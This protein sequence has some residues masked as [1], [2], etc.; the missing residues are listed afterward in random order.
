MDIFDK[1]NEEINVAGG[2]LYIFVPSQL[3]KEDIDHH[4]D[5][6]FYHLLHKA[7]EM[8]DTEKITLELSAKDIKYLRRATRIYHDVLSDLHLHKQ[9]KEVFECL[10]KESE[11]SIKGD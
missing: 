1:V 6:S 3:P 5:D 2:H 10:M 9:M 4:F 7:E 11:K 8:G